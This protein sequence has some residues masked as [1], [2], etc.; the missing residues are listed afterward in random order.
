MI[1][2]G[3]KHKCRWIKLFESSGTVLVTVLAVMVIL[4]I[5]FLAAFT[6]IA[7]RHSFH[8]K[9]QNQLIARHLSEAGITRRLNHLSEHG[10]SYD[11]ISFEAPN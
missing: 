11:S 3:W 4:L 8:I 1:L 2:S 9:Q 6:Y 7:N 5:L 10:V